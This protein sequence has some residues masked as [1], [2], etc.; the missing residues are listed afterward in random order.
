MKECSLKYAFHNGFWN[1][2]KI[3]I[4][5]NKT[6]TLLNLN[7]CANIL[8]LFCIQLINCQTAI[9]LKNVL[10]EQI[11]VAAPC[12]SFRTRTRLQLWSLRAKPTNR[13]VENQN[14]KT[15]WL[16]FC[17]LEL[18]AVSHHS[19]KFVCKTYSQISCFYFFTLPHMATCLN[20]HVTLLWLEAPQPRSPS[21]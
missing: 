8:K 18:L 6:T 10:V 7:F 5:N 4:F 15:T 14:H 19:D 17:G 12:G 3:S 16:R 2:R 20:G 9:L 1:L 11:S 21:C 13:I